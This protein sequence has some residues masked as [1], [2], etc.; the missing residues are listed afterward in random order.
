MARPRSISREGALERALLLFWEQGFEKSSVA[1]L[2]AVIGVGPSSLYNSFGSKENLFRLAIDRY[3]DTHL[4]PALEQIAARHAETAV[5]YVR[6]LMRELV[7]L[8]TD[9]NLPGGCALFEGAGPGSPEDAGA[10][11]IT[12]AI[13]GDLQGR[14]R[15]RLDAYARSGET[16]AASPR[17]LAAFLLGTLRGLSQL[18]RDGASRAELMK[19]VEHAA[20]SCSRHE[21][22]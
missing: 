18:A 3:L 4:A 1:D 6:N 9:K 12:H 14:L 2:S 15:K 11:A 8:Y 17:T 19:V 13:R 5:E 7:E 16:L 22:H 20:R 21:D 10:G